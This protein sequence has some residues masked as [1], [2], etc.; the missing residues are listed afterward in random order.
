M[1]EQTSKLD[2][3]PHDTDLTD[4]EGKLNP[5]WMR[6]FLKVRNKI[7]VI[8]SS[9]VNL[10]TATGTGFPANDGSGNWTYR[11]VKGTT[12]N[13]DVTTGDGSGDP[14]VDLPTI[15]GLTPGAYTN[16]NITVDTKG[17][18]VA[19]ANGGSGSSPL[20]TKG[21][22]Y[23]FSTANARLPVGADTYIL[24]A[25]STQPTGL[26]WAAPS[27]G[28]SPVTTKGDLYTF[29]TA[30]ARL[31]VGTDG[32]VLS[33]DSTQA[34]GL[35]WINNSSVSLPT[36]RY[37][38]I[39]DMSC[40]SSALSFAELRLR[41]TVGGADLSVSAATAS[42]TYSGDPIS[43]A[44]DGN[45]S[46]LWSSNSIVTGVT[47]IYDLGTPKTVAEVYILAR[48]DSSINAKQTPYGFSLSGSDDNVTFKKVA[49]FISFTNYTIG[50]AR[51]YDL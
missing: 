40:G 33:A 18:V 6:W 29:D 48:N 45:P 5:H 43:N 28:S 31:P 25:D 16:V 7:N 46:T 19:A 34:K 10:S 23:T 27:A 9:L 22:I 50:E 1:S 12:G 51:T 15:V 30:V 3:V 49:E 2:P 4:E 47:I 36:F 42:S 17:R 13:I 14:T 11:I 24:V 35:K 44:Y 38:L 39:S 41:S 21:D 37:W 26:K 32:Q 20:T 8:E